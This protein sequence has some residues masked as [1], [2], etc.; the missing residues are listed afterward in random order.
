MYCTTV[1]LPLREDS[2]AI[3]YTIHLSMILITLP[4]IHT[5]S[6]GAR[7]GLLRCDGVWSTPYRYS[8]LSS[9]PILYTLYTLCTLYTLYTVLYTFY[10]LFC[11]HH[12]YTLSVSRQINRTKN[13]THTVPPLFS[14]SLF[15]ILSLPLY[16]VPLFSSSLLSLSHTGGWGAGVDRLAMF[17]SNKWN[18]KEVLLFPAMKPEQ[19]GGGAP[20]AK[21]SPATAAIV[22]TPT[23]APAVIAKGPKFAQLEL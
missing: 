23:P 17:L 1:T 4:F 15:P 16:P 6:L 10:S 13:I 19:G 8:L 20:V 12:T 21:K 9:L 5:R 18:I 22:A 7:R 2:S 3:L 11:K 14:S